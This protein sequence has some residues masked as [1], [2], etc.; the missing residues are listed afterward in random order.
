MFVRRH[1]HIGAKPRTDHCAASEQSAP[2][3]FS[4]NHAAD[5]QDGS[6]HVHGRN[7]GNDN[8]DGGR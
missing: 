2:R 3:F 8:H 5:D 4:S 6:D 7:A 1:H